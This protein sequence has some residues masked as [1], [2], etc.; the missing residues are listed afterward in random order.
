MNKKLM[1]L[2]P[3]L[4]QAAEDDVWDSIIEATNYE[5]SETVF[6]SIYEEGLASI[7]VSI[8]NS[9]WNSVGSE[10]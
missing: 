10:I 5:V 3:L 2:W 6:R 7:G 9:V 4:W 1:S 8:G